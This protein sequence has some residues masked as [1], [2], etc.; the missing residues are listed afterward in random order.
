MTDDVMS[1]GVTA[2]RP[3]GSVSSSC[4]GSFVSFIPPAVVVICLCVDVMC[5]VC[6]FPCIYHG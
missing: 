1:E 2:E 6:V 5:A 4:R 3:I